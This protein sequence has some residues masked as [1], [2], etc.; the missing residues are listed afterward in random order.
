MTSESSGRPVEGVYVSVAGHATSDGPLYDEYLAAFTD[1]DGRYTIP[2]VPAGTYPH[3]TVRGAGLKL[4][5]L[6]NVRVEAREPTV[7]DVRMARNWA[8]IDGGAS[9]V[10]TTDDS[11]AEFGCGTEQGLDGLDRT[12]WSALNP[13]SSDPGNPHTGTPTAVLEL[14]RP[15]HIDTYVV[16]PTAGCNDD[17]TSSTSE[18]TLETSPDGVTFTPSV[19]GTG[20]NAFTAD[21]VFTSHRVTPQAGSAKNVRFIRLRLVSPLNGDPGC[22]CSGADFVDWTELEVLGRPSSGTF[23]PAGSLIADNPAPQVGRPVHFDASSFTDSEAVIT[24]YAWDFDG[25]GVTDRETIGPTA[26]FAYA[27][28][29][30]YTAKVTVTDY[31][32]AQ[33]TATKTISVSGPVGPT[34]RLGRQVRQARAG[35]TAMTAHRVDRGARR[36][37]GQRSGRRAGCDGSGQGGGGATG[38]RARRARTASRAHRVQAA[39]MA[40]GSGSTRPDGPTRPRRPAHRSGPSRPLRRAVRNPLLRPLHRGRTDRQVRR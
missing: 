16:T 28:L 25:D 33:G 3:V 23:A 13:N 7:R 18:Y 37:R 38:P 27:G 30:S 29:G 9:V 14:P 36:R 31:L 40:T 17:P 8:Q 11:A 10:S 20:A 4:V 21:E 34:E 24:G 39:R 2:N 26:A 35:P 19:D 1:A 12:V 22:G 6:D 15:V 32:G 5:Q